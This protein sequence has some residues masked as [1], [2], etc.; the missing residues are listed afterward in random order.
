MNTFQPVIKNRKTYDKHIH[1][2]PYKEGNTAWL[3]DAVIEK[4]QSKKFHHPWKGA[5][6]VLTKIS[7]CDYLI[8]STTGKHTQ[9]IAHFN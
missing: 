9:I 7:D 8:E 1:G 4:G 6:H 5:Y 3:F 2:E